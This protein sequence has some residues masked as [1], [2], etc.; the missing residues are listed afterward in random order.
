MAETIGS[1]YVLK[2]PKHKTGWRLMREFYLDSKRTQKT[3]PRT[4]WAALGF[5]D[6]MSLEQAKARA[7]EINQL[8]T[9]KR[10]EVNQVARIAER[11]ER[12]RLHHSA[13]VPKDLNETFL[14]WIDENVTGG[15][16][17]MNRV[18]FM[19][20]SA[21]RIA[22]KLQ[23]TPE[24]YASSKKQIYRYFSSNEYSLDYTKKVIGI[25]NKYGRFV[26][27]LTGKFYEDIAQPRGHDRE[28]IN[29]AYLDSETYIGPSEPL[30]PEILSSLEASLKP[31]QYSWLKASMWFGL[32]PSELDA[33][34]ADR[35]QKTWRV[36]PGVQ[37]KP[38]VLWVYQPKLTSIP[39]PK[40]WKPIPI[41]FNEQR[42]ALEI[43]YMG[44]AVVPLTK[45]IKNYTGDH[46][47]KYGGRKGFV[48]LM[49]DRGQSLENIAQWLGH[50]S[51]GITW[52]TYKNRM[53]VGFTKV[54]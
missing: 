15:E 34:L 4:A 47:T 48:D 12:D 45:T 6:S 23:L 5:T 19:W 53:H 9:I 51:I 44:E 49:L 3:V 43:L 28:M 10:T 1:L 46:V 21:K 14:K 35:S 52:K 20:E 54:K 22:I 38:D 13:F 37:D 17:H 8:N 32:R 18:R 41:L 29:D 30:T 16:A 27:R 42:E 33:V 31:E 50:T 26:G 36:E 11:V 40:R 24:H 7:R 2:S 39:R 25:M